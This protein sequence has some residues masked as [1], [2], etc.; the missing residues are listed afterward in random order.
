MGGGSSKPSTCELKAYTQPNAYGNKLH[1]KLNSNN[2]NEVQALWDLSIFAKQM[3]NDINSIYL[4]GP[5]CWMQACD[6]THFTGKCI[7]WK[8]NKSANFWWGTEHSN[9]ISSIRVGYGDRI[10]EWRGRRME[11]E[12]VDYDAELTASGIEKEM[13]PPARNPL[14][15]ALYE[16][17]FDTNWEMFSNSTILEQE[18]IKLAKSCETEFTSED[19]TATCKFLVFVGI[20]LIEP[21]AIVEELLIKRSSDSDAAEKKH[22]EALKKQLLDHVEEGEL[23]GIDLM[24][25]DGEAY[26]VLDD[27]VT[28]E[29][30]AQTDGS[31]YAA[32]IG[33]TLIKVTNA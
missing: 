27:P 1:M 3:D 32:L 20:E 28:D 24:T 10:P 22:C 33:K 17:G 12:L 9:M 11:S 21:D 23:T 7:T 5:D 31:H 25:I 8:D 30:E 19:E 13:K 6:H 26:F 15:D 16:E 18:V 14:C 2:A 29:S 4:D